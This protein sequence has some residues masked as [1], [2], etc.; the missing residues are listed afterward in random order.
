M[1]RPLKLALTVVLGLALGLLGVLLVFTDIGPT[2]TELGRLLTGVVLFLTAGLGLGYLNPEGRAWVLAGLAAWG[3]AALGAYGLWLSLTHPP[4]AD[5]PLAL[6]FLIG[7]LALAL[8]GGWLGARLRRP[9][10][11]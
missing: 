5:L 3:L 7:P 8:L 11:P 6:T 1:P 9:R 2:R 4:S 10:G